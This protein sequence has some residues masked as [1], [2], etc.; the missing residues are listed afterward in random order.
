MGV[1]HVRKVGIIVKS[2]L[3]FFVSPAD[4]RVFFGV[5]FTIAPSLPPPPPIIFLLIIFCHQHIHIRVKTSI[6]RP[7]RK[8][9]ILSLQ[10]WHSYVSN[11]TFLWN[12]SYFDFLKP[13]FHF[14]P[15]TLPPSRDSLPGPTAVVGSLLMDE[16]QP[17]RTSRLDKWFNVTRGGE[18]CCL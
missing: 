14:N 11:R 10:P 6:S 7:F 16:T 18:V 8:V 5:H 1:V 9:S 4:F 2:L 3:K 13:F 15:F 12:S 17:Q